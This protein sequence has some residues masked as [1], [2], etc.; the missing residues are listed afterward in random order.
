MSR[1]KQRKNRWA[2]APP[3][4]PESSAISGEFR[5]TKQKRRRSIGS[6][7]QAPEATGS[8]LGSPVPPSLGAESWSDPSKDGSGSR[9][10]AASPDPTPQALPELEPHDSARTTLFSEQAFALSPPSATH[11]SSTAHAPTDRATLAAQDQ[12]E[13]ETLPAPKGDEAA[14]E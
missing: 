14:T 5:F 9:E 8:L 10:L 2:I 1:A 7:E 4:S 12:S 11:S 6:W 13:P 3:P